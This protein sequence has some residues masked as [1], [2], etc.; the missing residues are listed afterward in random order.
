MIFPNKDFSFE[1]SL[2]YKSIC[3]YNNLE[4]KI[5]IESIYEMYSDLN[6]KD[7]EVILIFLYCIKKIDIIGS[8]VVKL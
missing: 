6:L 5:K 1:K 2:L 4:D 3:I 7:L 8:E